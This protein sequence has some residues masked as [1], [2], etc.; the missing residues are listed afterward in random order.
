MMHAKQGVATVTIQYEIRLL[1]QLQL[2]YLLK[3]CEF[4]WLHCKRI[5]QL[6]LYCTS[7]RVAQRVFAAAGIQGPI[8]LNHNCCYPSNHGCCQVNQD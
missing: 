7:D 2:T 8:V 5:D 6:L 3:Q 1:L 4:V